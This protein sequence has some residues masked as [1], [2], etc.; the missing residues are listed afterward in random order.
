MAD[1]QKFTVK[2]SKAGRTVIKR[3]IT[4]FLAKKVDLNPD[5]EETAGD[6]IEA[7]ATGFLQSQAEK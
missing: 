4:L 3:A 5:N 1:K 2:V 7:L 6:V